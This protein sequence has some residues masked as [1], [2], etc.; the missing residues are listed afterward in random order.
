M[1]F[2]LVLLKVKIEKISFVISAAKAAMKSSN[3]SNVS[4]S[5]VGS[6]TSLKSNS[7]VN[8]STQNRSRAASGA[9]RSRAASGA[10]RSGAAGLAQSKL[11]LLKSKP[12]A[13]GRS[14]AMK[15]T[16]YITS[17]YKRNCKNKKE[18][19]YLKYTKNIIICKILVT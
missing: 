12:T 18:F 4:S 17:N 2:F 1:F 3:K 19:N 11:V 10:N 8:R 6:N 5:S 9:N 7:S 13:K 14:F 15:G 16:V